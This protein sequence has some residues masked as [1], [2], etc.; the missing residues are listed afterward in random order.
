MGW[1]GRAAKAVEA[2]REGVMTGGVAVAKHGFVTTSDL[3]K[4]GWTRTLIK[5]FLPKPDCWLPV[6]HWKNYR[7]QNAYSASR[8]WHVEQSGEFEV[9]F[10][11]TWRGR[12][13]QEDVWSR[14]L[15]IRRSEH[16]DVRQMSVEELRLQTLAANAAG[17]LDLVRRQGFR[18]PHK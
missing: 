10:L 12:M 17:Q 14:L 2:H 1:N 18:T 8:I 9:A 11:K 5:R 7:G 6:D 15:A 4:R 13:Q 3:V 16:P